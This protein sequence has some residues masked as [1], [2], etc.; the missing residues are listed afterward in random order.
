MAR[1]AAFGIVGGSGATG[2]AVMAQLLPPFGDGEILLGARDLARA[3]R[4]AGAGGNSVS[5]SRLDVFDSAALDE[6]CSR[7]SI[8]INCAGP[9]RTLGDRVAQAC[10]R[11]RCHYIDVASLS[12]VRDGI[13]RHS[14]E[15]AEQGLSFVLSAGWSPG[16]TELIPAFAHAQA[17]A[18]MD[19][20]ESLTAYFGDAG[21]WSVNALRDAVWYIHERGLQRPSVLRMGKPA[22]AQL[23]AV[24][25][26]ADLGE[27]V[28]SQRFSLFSTPELDSLGRR[29]ADCDVYTY[30]Y[31]P[32]TRAA[33]VAVAIA[34]LPLPER[35]ALRLLGD[36]LRRH[37]L[38]VG[39]FV[40]THVLGQ[41]KGR[42][43]V[44]RVQLTYAQ[45]R[46]YW[47][48]GLVPA[49]VARSIAEGRIVRPG[50][51]FLADAVDPGLFV[52]E[53]RRAGVVLTETFTS[54]D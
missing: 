10:F 1:Q 33:I 41:C 13:D 49:I 35:F 9:L 3:A 48:N 23:S 34:L 8:V 4:V 43:C 54:R 30:A 12:V 7:C 31:V 45:Q 37:D 44:L 11:Q 2:S 16:L 25:R 39:G 40:A 6:F 46:E 32:S 26:R 52:D 29:L 24:S 47:I 38:P 14:R 20:L 22:R 19:R 53:L 36:V 28:G 18:R 21:G 27:A 15:I 42:P 17:M 50:V 5:A 51:H